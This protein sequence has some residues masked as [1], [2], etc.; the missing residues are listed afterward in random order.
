M[1]RLRNLEWL[2]HNTE[3][4][5]PLT[6]DA[7]AKDLTD[8][9][10]LP[11]D[12]IVS[13]YLSVH[14]GLNVDPAKFFIK[15]VGVYSSGFS[16]VVGYDADSGAVPVA[17]ALIARASHSVY[18]PYRLGGLGDFVDTTG[19]IVIG[20]LDNI[21]EQPAGQFEFDLAG[22]RLEVDAVRPL[23]RGIS[24]LQVQNGSDLSDRIYGHVV[25]RAGNNFRI[26]PVIEAGQDPEIVFDAIEGDGLNE[27][28]VCPGDE[29]SVPIRYINQIPPDADGNFTLVG[30]D[31]IDI[32]PLST[33][34]R[35]SDECSDPC[36]GCEELQV[37][38]QELETFGRQATTLE[39]FLVD[40]ESRVT[41]MD[42]VVL[43]SR[44]GDQGCFSCD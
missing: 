11:E 38:T 28:C 16:V 33:G 26:T 21:D 5:Y 9:F 19:T 34:V 32:S 13:L 22:G 40:L 3:R 27:E 30:N 8:S 25:L 7:T 17:S 10:E 35:L 6:L 18:T 42:Q 20:K 12:F 41:Q 36:C 23:I 29:A 4:N 14:A 1:S 39:N 24:S 37:I 15:T 31:C 43:G 44:L 2:D